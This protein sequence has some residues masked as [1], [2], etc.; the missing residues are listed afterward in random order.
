MSKRYCRC[1]IPTKISNK[2][3]QNSDQ[4]GRSKKSVTTPSLNKVVKLVKSIKPM[5]IKPMMEPLAAKYGRILKNPFAPEAM[6][7]RCPDSYSFPTATYHLKGTMVVTSGPT[8]TY[9][10]QCGVLFTPNPLLSVVD[11]LFDKSSSATSCI[12][13]TNSS[14]VNFGT[15]LTYGATTPDL[16]G[17]V[18]A[19]SRVVSWGVKITNLQPELS[20]TGR[21]Y[22]ALVPTLSNIPS[23]KLLAATNIATGSLTQM[24][25]GLATSA[26][27]SGS[28]EEQPT[29]THIAVQDLLHGDIMISGSYT[30]PDFFT[31]RSVQGSEVY[32]VGTALATQIVSNGVNVLAQG[33][34]DQCNMMGGVAIA[35]YAEGCPANTPCFDVEYIYHLEGTP[36]VSSVSGSLASGSAPVSLLGTRNIVESAMN[37]VAGSN[38]VSWLDKGLA[39]VNNAAQTMGKIGNSPA[40]KLAAGFFGL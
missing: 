40:A 1:H 17:S 33:N 27:A 11:T 30:N 15:A 3:K 28:L 38:S 35:F 21:I 32:G 19:T 8:G 23:V 6:G 39:F 37:M 4:N 25:C 18:L 29:S 12:A 9:V 13:T 14:L 34:S 16:L 20:A 7:S 22:I 10:G 5:S 26:V 36:T 24:V 31:L 2:I